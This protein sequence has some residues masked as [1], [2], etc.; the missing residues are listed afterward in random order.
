MLATASTDDGYDMLNILVNGSR[1][2]DEF[3]ILNFSGSRFPDDKESIHHTWIPSLQ[4]CPGQ[5]V[6]VSMLEKGETS[7]R[8]KTFEEMF[9]NIDKAA[10][11]EECLLRRDE[12]V[13]ALKARPKLRSGYGFTLIV[14]GGTAFTGYTS[15]QED[16]L[17]CSM[18]W[19]HWQPQHTRLSL[20][21]SGA[22][23][24]NDLTCREL[25]VGESLHLQLDTLTLP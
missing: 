13:T 2:H 23:G 5:V 22:D 18:M 9:P 10:F 14:P 15:P 8:G 19:D 12:L 21:S 6:T 17:H 7:H 3:A 25:R 11:G 4:L 20:C 24:R 16:S 1:I